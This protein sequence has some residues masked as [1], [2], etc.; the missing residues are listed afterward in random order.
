MNRH[1]VTT[2]IPITCSIRHPPVG[3]E[4]TTTKTTSISNTLC[5]AL[6]QCGDDNYVR[7]PIPVCT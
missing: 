7:A 1:E 4:C 3:R 5:N 2:R 6:R